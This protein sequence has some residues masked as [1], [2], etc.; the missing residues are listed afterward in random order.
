MEITIS[1][2]WII[3]GI[4]LIHTALTHIISGGFR[5]A[6]NDESGSALLFMFLI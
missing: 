5:E 2:Y 6:R 1:L 3:L 4:I